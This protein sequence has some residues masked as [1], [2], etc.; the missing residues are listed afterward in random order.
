LTDDGEDPLNNNIDNY[1]GLTLTELCA[2]NLFFSLVGKC[3]EKGIF[4][5]DDL[6]YVDSQL[7]RMIEETARFCGK[8]YIKEDSARVML[9]NIFMILDGV[10]SI[11][12]FPEIIKVIKSRTLWDMWQ[13]GTKESI[14]HF[15]RTRKNFYHLEHFYYKY[16]DLRADFAI[17]LKN[18]YA[19]SN[20][21]THSFENAKFTKAFF[22]VSENESFRSVC[23]RS[24]MLCT[25]CALLSGIG[26]S[27]ILPILNERGSFRIDGGVKYTSVLVD[28]IIISMCFSAFY[29]C[30]GIF[31]ETK[32]AKE[33]LTQLISSDT[34]ELCED[35]GSYLHM[36]IARYG[37]ETVNKQDS[38]GENILNV[39][40][41]RLNEE[42][43]KSLS[44]Y[45]V[46]VISGKRTN[47]KGLRN[48]IHFV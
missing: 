12:D 26:Y 22:A 40:A 27:D 39:Y 17:S 33:I 23:Q 24:E 25:E 13:R 38:Y 35:I 37:V 10:Y 6:V 29:R 32:Y 19:F 46:S 31:P 20:I 44:D 15:D 18:D 5:S 2:D 9:K 41:S 42:N 30:E 14:A 43:I 16:P 34:A 36:V 3:K 1:Y 47:E 45:L 7:N 11:A 28:A 8:G 4:D 48:L 21:Y